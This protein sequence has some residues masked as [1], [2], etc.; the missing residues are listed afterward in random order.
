MAATTNEL[1]HHEPEPDAHDAANVT[2]YE[3]DSRIAVVASH[4]D[5]ESDYESDTES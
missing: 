5:V 4:A 2:K 1:E 3:F